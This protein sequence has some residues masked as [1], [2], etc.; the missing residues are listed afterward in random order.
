[1]D[2]LSDTQRLALLI[3]ER[4]IILE[5]LEI[6]EAKYI[7]SFRVTTPDPSLLDL[8]APPTDTDG[9]AYISRPKVLGGTAARRVCTFYL[10]DVLFLIRLPS[11]QAAGGEGVATLP[12]GLLLSPLRRMSRLPVT[13]SL[14]YVGSMG[15]GSPTTLAPASR[16]LSISAS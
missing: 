10:L 9:I 16:I 13:I 12:M 7:S 3:E 2:R 1:M 15:V 5:Q 6:A 8:N 11:K 14:A 4:D